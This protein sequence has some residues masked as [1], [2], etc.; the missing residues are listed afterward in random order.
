MLSDLTK[1][2]QYNYL[3]KYTDKIAEFTK[4]K[5]PNIKKF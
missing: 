2:E 4:N 3:S 1:E 5:I